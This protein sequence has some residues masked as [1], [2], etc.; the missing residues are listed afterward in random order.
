VG[1]AWG[2]I[3]LG[4]FADGT[5]GDGWNGVKGP[6]AG[7]FYGD[8]G[9][10]IAQMIEVVVCFSFIFSISYLFF[11][12]LDK[13]VGNRVSPEMEIEGLDIP[14][15]GVKGYQDSIEGYK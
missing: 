7:L 13:C 4:L 1:G 3:S 8:A 5:Y 6:V 9:Q 10:L 11:K 12:I 15:M 2:I 14:E